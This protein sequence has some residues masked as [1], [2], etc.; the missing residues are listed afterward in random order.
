VRT[1]NPTEYSAVATAIR[2]DR[3]SRHGA[4]MKLLKKVPDFKL[5]ID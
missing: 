2:M 5:A 3:R 1:S 4:N